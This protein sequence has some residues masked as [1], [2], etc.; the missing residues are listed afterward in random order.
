MVIRHFSAPSWKRSVFFSSTSQT[1]HFFRFYF[2]QSTGRKSTIMYNTLAKGLFLRW[3]LIVFEVSAVVNHALYIR[4]RNLVPRSHSVTGN[5]KSGKVRQ[6]TIFHW[7]LKKVAAMQSTLR[8]AYFAGH[9][10]KVW[11]SQAHVLF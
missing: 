5:V 7:L 6:Y 11:F 8:L 10:V 4:V 3:K 2:F 9:L 1:S